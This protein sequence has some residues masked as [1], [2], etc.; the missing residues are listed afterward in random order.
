MELH[1]GPLSVEDRTGAW[2]RGTDGCKETAAPR[3]PAQLAGPVAAMDAWAAIGSCP[4][5]HGIESRPCSKE[6]KSCGLLAPR[7][8]SEA[9]DMPDFA[10][11]RLLALPDDVCIA[12]LTFLEDP[13]TICAARAVCKAMRR[14][15]SAPLLWIRLTERRWQTLHPAAC[16]A[17]VTPSELASDGQTVAKREGGVVPECLSGATLADVC[18]RLVPWPTS[19]RAFPGPHHEEIDPEVTVSFADN[20]TIHFRGPRNS[21]G[22]TVYARADVP[23]PFETANSATAVAPPMD[24]FPFATEGAGL[25]S[26][27]SWALRTTAYFE[28]EL[29]AALPPRPGGVAIRLEDEETTTL[30]SEGPRRSKTFVVMMPAAHEPC[31]RPS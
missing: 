17:K 4:E 30:T 2:R 23:F 5:P 18:C 21:I 29:P 3:S 25:G 14:A 9:S 24:P 6:G 22:P 19:M 8:H 7:L 28:A 1:C 13:P 27:R 12:V 11:A 31:A 20:D 15:T 16:R 10:E 26:P